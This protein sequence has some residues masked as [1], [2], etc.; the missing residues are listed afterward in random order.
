MASIAV[1]FFRA[2]RPKEEVPFI[3]EDEYKQAGREVHFDEDKTTQV[4]G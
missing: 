1:D 4:N 3:I 2:M